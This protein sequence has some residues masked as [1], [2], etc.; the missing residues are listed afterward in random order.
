MAALLW[1]VWWFLFM[2]VDRP[3]ARLAHISTKTVANNVSNIL[4]K[5]HVSGRAQAIVAAR[6]AGLGG[7]TRS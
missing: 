4:S 1:A 5:L 3:I 6:E 7:G 2:V